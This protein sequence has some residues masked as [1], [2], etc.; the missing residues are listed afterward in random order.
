MGHGDADG[1]A[2]DDDLR[3]LDPFQ[4]PHRF[5]LDLFE[6]VSRD[7]EI[8]GAQRCLHHTAGDAEQGSGSGVVTENAVGLAVGQVEEVDS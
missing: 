8:G 4:S 5:E 2:V 1:S 6:V 7:E 3:L